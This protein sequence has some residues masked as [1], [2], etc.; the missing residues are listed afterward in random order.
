MTSLPVPGQYSN[1][2][3]MQLPQEPSLHRKMGGVWAVDRLACG[4]AAG[5]AD[6]RE[7]AERRGMGRRWK[8]LMSIVE[9]A[10]MCCVR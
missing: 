5:M 2:R 6:A 9:V 1:G 7:V 8:R 10:E 3:L 4:A